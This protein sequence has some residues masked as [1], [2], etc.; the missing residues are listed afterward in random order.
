MLTR[1]EKAIQNFFPGILLA[2]CALL[3]SAADLCL[4]Q[5]ATPVRGTN[6]PLA[7]GLV[8][9]DAQPERG[10][11]YPYYLY[12][13]PELL[14]DGKHS[15]THTLLVLP[16]KDGKTDVDFAVHDRFARELAEAPP[17]RDLAANMKTAMLVPVF[18]RPKSDLMVYTHAL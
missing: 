14:A 4:A 2:A 11:L 17:N 13:P 10:F 5:S 1:K 6:P 9:F 16:N 12:T 7:P 8:R 18:P 15:G 3:L